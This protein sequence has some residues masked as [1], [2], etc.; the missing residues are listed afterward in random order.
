MRELSN[1]KVTFV[2]PASVYAQEFIDWFSE[3]EQSEILFLKDLKIVSDNNEIHFSEN[4]ETKNTREKQESLNSF[5]KENIQLARFLAISNS[6]LGKVDLVSRI[7]MNQR[8]IEAIHKDI[9]D[10]LL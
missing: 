9:I 6:P 5:I 10:G 1:T 2:F 4:K 7:E 3:Q 8:Q